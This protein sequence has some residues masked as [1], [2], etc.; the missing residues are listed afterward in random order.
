MRVIICDVLLNS[1]QRRSGAV[2]QIKYCNLHH[3]TIRWF[4]VA[5]TVREP[6]LWLAV[7]VSDLMAT[8]VSE[9]IGSVVAP[10]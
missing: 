8:I 3:L 10:Y 7:G 5:M 6:T 2:V 9:L 4:L 1:N